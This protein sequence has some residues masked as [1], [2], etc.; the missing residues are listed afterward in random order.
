MC[1]VLIIED[2]WLIADYVEQLARDAGATSAEIA[3][4]EVD[5][6]EP[7]RVCRRPFGLSY[8]AMGRS[9]SMA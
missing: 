6:I 4:C 3:D 2:E 8:A 7:R 1:P 5:A 9:S